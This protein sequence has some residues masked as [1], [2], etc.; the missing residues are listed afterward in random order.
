M[1]EDAA[2]D[3]VSFNAAKS[4]SAPTMTI[5]KSQELCCRYLHVLQM[6]ILDDL[7]PLRRLFTACTP[8]LCD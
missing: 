1:K 8:L 4:N 7:L 3:F 6:L 2:I 5:N